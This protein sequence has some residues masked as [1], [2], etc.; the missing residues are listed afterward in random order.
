MLKQIALSDLELG[1]FVHKMQGNWFDHPFWK[2]KFLIEDEKSLRTLQASQLEAVVIDTA[3]G[4][5]TAPA[6]RPAPLPAAKPSAGQR[7]AAAAPSQSRVASLKARASVDRKQ[8]QPASTEAEVRNAQALAERA[9]DRVQNTFLAARLGKAFNARAVEPVIGDIL[10]SVRRNPQ[11]FGGLMR[12]KLRN[13]FAYQ[14][15]LAVSALMISLGRQMK[16]NETQIREAGLAGLLLDIGVNYLPV[17]L[18]P[19]NGDFR[20]VD[21]VFWRQHVMLGYRALQNDDY[22]PQA[23]L[24]ACLQHHERIDGGGFPNGLAGDDISRI[25]RMAAICDSFDFLLT[26]TATTRALD[27]GAAILALLKTEGEFD[28][29]ILRSFVDSVGLYPAGTFVRLAS[30]KLAMVI[31]L[32]PRDS[33]KPIVQAFYSYETGERIIP[34]RIELAR[35]TGK[36]AII[37]IADLDGLGLPEDRQLRELLF[38][39]AHK[40]TQV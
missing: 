8:D 25:A 23:V 36:N 10:A 2:S 39:S 26:G 6:P 17:N 20:N 19:T 31:D 40:L 33:T 12:C 13:E 1:M 34:H 11:A 29:D 38:L 21:P 30:D 37:E 22:L 24:D 14:H 7:S 9:K 16:L 5:D 35:D 32:D 28:P 15:S 18:H 3:K 4:K 27:P